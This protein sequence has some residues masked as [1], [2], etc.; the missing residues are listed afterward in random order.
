MAHDEQILALAAG[1]AVRE[2]AE[3]AG[4]GEPIAQGRLA[5]AVFRR[6]EG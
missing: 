3:R 2:A 4:S 5:D 1:A 6:A